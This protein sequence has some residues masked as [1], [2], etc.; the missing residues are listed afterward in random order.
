MHK[1]ITFNTDFSTK[2]VCGFLAA[3]TMKKNTLDFKRKKMKISF[4][5]I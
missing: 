2:I 4:H 1:T 3:A 5:E